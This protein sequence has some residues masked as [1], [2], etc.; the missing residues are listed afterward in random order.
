[1]AWTIAV[2]AFVAAVAAIGWYRLH[3]NAH[4]ESELNLTNFLISILYDDE[5]RKRVAAETFDY[6]TKL[7]PTVDSRLVAHTS[8][9]FIKI[10]NE[11]FGNAKARQDMLAMLIGI[12]AARD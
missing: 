3:A 10:A 4:M 5:E 6:V 12:N 7:P 9:H 8:A 1:M 11:N 2:V